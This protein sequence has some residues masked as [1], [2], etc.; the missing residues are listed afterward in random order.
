MK[1]NG[2]TTEK[3]KNLTGKEIIHYFALFLGNWT[4]QDFK[5]AFKKSPLGWD[6]FWG[7]LRSR[8][9]NH[10]KS[11]EN[12]TNALVGIVLNMDEFHQNMLFDYIFNSEYSER[13]LKQRET[14]LW[15]EEQ[16]EEQ[17]RRIKIGKI[18]PDETK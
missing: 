18:Y 14:N 10:L 9:G 15:F 11:P 7:K 3:V 12:P 6:Y 13:I 16:I 1:G 17:G 2:I 4:E 5:I 8:S